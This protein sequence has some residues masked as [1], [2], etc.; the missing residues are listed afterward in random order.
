M[1]IKTIST[2]VKS[3]ILAQNIHLTIRNSNLRVRCT[4]LKRKTT[5]TLVII[6]AI[7]YS[8]SLSV[9]CQRGGFPAWLSVKSCSRLVQIPRW[10]LQM[11][12]CLS[13]WLSVCLIRAFF[14]VFYHFCYGMGPTQTLEIAGRNRQ[15]FRDFRQHCRSL[16]TM[17]L[18][19][20]YW[21]YFSMVPRATQWNKMML[22]RCISV[23]WSWKVLLT[24]NPYLKKDEKILQRSI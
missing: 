16:P 11:G 8:T 24:G 21:D 19:I 1:N 13:S 6:T 4:R 14:S 20:L 9:I 10:K 2:V 22:A 15:S 17:E 23:Q 7:P 18:Q 3:Q 5:S 12:S